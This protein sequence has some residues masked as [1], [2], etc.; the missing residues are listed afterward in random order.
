MADLVFLLNLDESSKLREL[1]IETY[2]G[3]IPHLK[4]RQYSGPLRSTNIERVDKFD[5]MSPAIFEA[6]RSQLRSFSYIQISKSQF[7]A[8]E[9][10]LP[11]L[12]QLMSAG[13]LFARRRKS[14]MYQIDDIQKMTEK[15]KKDIC[16]ANGRIRL[17]KNTLY[18][19][20]DRSVDVQEKGSPTARAFV[21]L[22]SKGH[23]LDLEF[24]YP[25][26]IGLV[27]AGTV[28]SRLIDYRFEREIAEIVNT[29]KWRRQNGGNQYAYIGNAFRRDLLKLVN[30]PIEVYAEGDKRVRAIESSSLSVS[31]GIDWFE[32]N[33]TVRIGSKDLG[34][35]DFASLKRLRG[36]WVE[37]DDEIIPVP[38][39]LARTADCASAASLDSIRLPRQDLLLAI[40]V[41]SRFGDGTIDKLDKLT[42]YSSV[43][44][45]S[46]EQVAKAIRPYQS[47]GIRWLL[48]IKANGFGGCLADDM[49][50][51]KTLQAIGFLSDHSRIGDSNLIVVPKTLITNWA[52]ELA[53]FAP[54]MKIDIYHGSNRNPVRLN[55]TPTL[56]TTYGTLLNDI[57]LFAHHE[58]DNLIIDEAQAIKNVKSKKHRAVKAVKA[59]TRIAL[60]GT[61]IENNIEEYWGLMQL[62]NPPLFGDKAIPVRDF[63]DENCLHRMHHATSPFI[64]RRT[65]EEVLNDLPEKRTQ[66]LF[67]EMEGSQ[68]ELYDSV[69]EAIRIDLTSK[70]KPH[71]IKSGA[72]VLKGLLY[73]QEICCHPNLLPRSIRKK[74]FAESAKTELLL[75]L[76]RDLTGS[77]HKVVVFSRFSRMLK[78]IDKSLSAWEIRSFFLDGSINDRAQ[79]VDEFEQSEDGIFLIS[80]KAG[81]VGL[82]LVSADTVV[83][84]DPWWNPAVE[85]QAEDRVFR[86]GQ[87]KNVMVYKLIAANTIE[88]KILLLQEKKELISS[89]VLAGH[90]TPQQITLDEL[91]EALLAG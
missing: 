31:Y 42:D 75:E 14:P 10:E 20:V 86:I 18:I 54:D 68:K 41:A 84:Y 6:I 88:E 8:H 24:V 59:K 26:D 1:L 9:I 61:P 73:L 62:L 36:N 85:H 45:D 78:I 11:M 89:S 29:C 83:I 77:G 25:H 81:G 80:L 23:P 37:L 30:S 2:E 72:F 79:V 5:N 74:C 71:E 63:Q 47:I 46:N 58:Y 50:L 7:I 4:N 76:L 66:T 90:Q 27:S 21:D 28:A 51:G 91:E 13:C 52:R 67:C 12:D 32:V 40:E 34:I 65:K 44:L 22:G 64:L 48:S 16:L 43:S 69:L 19:R 15:S 17:E 33:G 87:T 35:A 3:S 38:D 82:N 39:F 53:R 60:T 70:N 57:D 55:D 56:I 49:G